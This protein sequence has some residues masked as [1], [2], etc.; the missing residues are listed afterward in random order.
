M[1]KSK[2]LSVFRLAMINLAAIVSIKNLPLIAEYGLSSVFLLIVACL[3]F[4]IPVALVSAELAS[5]YPQSGGVLVWAQRAFGPKVGFLAIWLLWIENALWYPTILSFI[6][7]TICYFINPDLINNKL[8]ISSFILAS[9]WIFTWMNSKGMELS[10][11]IST[12]GFSMGTLIPAVAII[13]MAAIWYFTGHPIQFSF[14]WDNF[15]PKLNSTGDM[16]FFA[17]ILLSLC[18]M[19]MSAVHVK[20]VQNPQRNFPRAVLLSSVVVF[21]MLTLGVLS[22][23]AILPNSEINIVAGSMQ[24]FEI[25][26]RNFNLQGLMPL[27]SI[28]VS[29]GALAAVSTWIAGPSKGLL[30][31]ADEGSL[32]KTFTKLNKHGMPQNL[33]VAQGIIV[34]IMA[35]LFVLMPS[36]SSAFWIVTAIVAQLYLLMYIIIFAAA[37]VLR[38]KDSSRLRPFKVPMGNI[39]MWITAGLGIFA[40]TFAVI[41]GFFPPSQLDGISM[42]GY[43][44]S[45]VFGIVFLC[46]LPFF[47]YYSVNKSKKRRS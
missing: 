4:F 6:A 29:I 19:E 14:T 39:G 42:A 34:S 17:G 36:V 18:G 22:I 37:I 27:M 21:L 11:W 47:I 33:L 16:V 12:L 20:D 3:I 26:L 44:A 46:I 2:S 31:A 7:T 28:L 15:I 9:F 25:F 45:M 23:A 8:F 38:Y 30:A 13:S 41:V 5:A 40:S 10:S 32:P 1:S 43:V 35:L 24:A